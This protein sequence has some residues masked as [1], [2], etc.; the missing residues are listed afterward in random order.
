MALLK[1]RLYKFCITQQS[2]TLTQKTPLI[3]IVY[4]SFI[5]TSKHVEK[6]KTIGVNV[7]CCILMWKKRHVCFYIP[8]ILGKIAIY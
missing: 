4:S 1:M 2:Y 7:N 8:L 6:S 3:Y 5:N